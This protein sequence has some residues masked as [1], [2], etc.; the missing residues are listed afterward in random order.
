M[1]ARGATTI[2]PAARIFAA[3]HVTA[4]E[5]LRELRATFRYIRPL[6]R[7]STADQHLF[8]LDG[9]REVVVGTISPVSQPFCESC[10]RLR[11]D[12]NGRLHACLRRADSLPLAPL[13]T[14]ENGPH[15]I[16]ACV[17][18]VMADKRASECWPARAMVAIGG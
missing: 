7:A 11:L 16:A 13:L 1:P 8:D 10:N 6:G 15:L 2:G 14:A 4:A 17:R 5:A 3:E 12:A 9:E 18:Q